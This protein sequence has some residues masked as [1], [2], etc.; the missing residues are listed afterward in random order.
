MAK[1]P[2]LSSDIAAQRE[3]LALPDGGIAGLLC[4]PDD[5]E[6]ISYAMSRLVNEPSLR[7][8][9]SARAALLGPSLNVDH[10]GDGYS[11]LFRM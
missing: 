1:S 5:I 3:V 11:A 7:H 10:M 6:K 9:L 2:I 8:E 4:A